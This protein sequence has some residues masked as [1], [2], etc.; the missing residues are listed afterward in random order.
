MTSDDDA[1]VLEC[2]ANFQRAIEQIEALQAR[3]KQLL[4][5]VDKQQTLIQ[6][7][8]QQAAL[9]RQELDAL[10][11]ALKAETEARKL[12]ALRANLA[13][14]R[15]KALSVQLE[16]LRSR[17]KWKSLGSFAIGFA[18]GAGATAAGVGR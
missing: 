5:L 12:E 3:Q 4:E 6:A 16:K 18:L 7:Q 9:F 17:S 2:V 14:G 10:R 15:L 11:A 8:E 1:L 13:E